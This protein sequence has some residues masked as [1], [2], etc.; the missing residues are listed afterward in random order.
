MILND[1]RIVCYYYNSSTERQDDIS[2][3]DIVNGASRPVWR[4]KVFPT[5]IDASVSRGSTCTLP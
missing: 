3:Q 5:L 1:T 2:E 4:G